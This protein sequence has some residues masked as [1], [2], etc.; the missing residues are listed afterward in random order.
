MCQQ[1]NVWAQRLLVDALSQRPLRPYEDAPQGALPQ[2]KFAALVA[3]LL[4]NTTSPTDQTKEQFAEFRH[5]IESLPATTLRDIV[6]MC[7]YAQQM[8][9]YLQDGA[10]YAMKRR[11]AQGDTFA[12]VFIIDWAAKERMN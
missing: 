8:F 11:A 2:E 6:T 1:C 5:L 4:D 3:K 12:Q 7:C 10:S 9:E